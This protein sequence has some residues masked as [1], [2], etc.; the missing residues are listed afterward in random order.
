M[1]K[2]CSTFLIHNNN[3]CTITIYT[4]YGVGSEFRTFGVRSVTFWSGLRCQSV[5]CIH[6]VFCLQSYAAVHE[7]IMITFRST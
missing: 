3:V 1:P 2:M 4:Q 7:R 6:R 5:H